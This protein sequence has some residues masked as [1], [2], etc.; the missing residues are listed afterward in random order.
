MSTH[1]QP[2]PASDSATS[3]R[4]EAR[5]ADYV[6]FLHRVP[7]VIDALNMGFLPG[8]REDC[9]YQQQQFTDLECP[10][11]MLD[12]DFRNPDLN[13]YVDRV[14]EHEPCV[15]IVGDAYNAAEARR[16]VDA[17]RELEGSF[18]DS[19]FIVVPK[20]REA[21]EAVPDDI[22]LGYSRGYA[23]TLAHDFSDPVDWRGRRV[24]ILGG[25]PPKQL[26]V[27]D[28]LTQPTLT[29]EPPAKIVGL[30]WNGVHR[31]AQFGEF[32][33]ADGW[34]DSGR[35]ADHVSVRDAVRYGLDH[36]RSFWQAHGVWPKT[37]SGRT[38]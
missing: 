8:F 20:C 36:V 27:I 7:F 34:D 16:Y 17:I 38:R 13:R 1:D 9:S 21:I 10:V 4:A 6:A 25:S 37:T 14:F 19:E 23:D 24:H 11:G 12:N 5:Q 28:R 26:D 15:G 2:A 29:D 3:T 32:W 35:E 22:V 30:D 31:G 18:P 33:T